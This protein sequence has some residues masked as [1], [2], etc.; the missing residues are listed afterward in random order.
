MVLPIAQIM[1]P[2]RSATLPL[3]PVSISSNIRVGIPANL[4]ITDLRLS[5][6]RDNSPPDATFD[7]SSGAPPL[8]AKRKATPSLPE[9]PGCTSSTFTSKRAPSS[10]RN[11]KESIMVADN[12]GAAACRFFESD[13]H[14]SR[15]FSFISEDFRSRAANSSSRSCVP[16]TD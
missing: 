4:A 5:I 10:S 15:Y 1:R 12:F 16:D 8:A 13:K 9:T 11:R 3:T 6:M 2:I 7:S 14:A